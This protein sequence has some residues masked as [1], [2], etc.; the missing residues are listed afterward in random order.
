MGCG[1]GTFAVLLATRGVRV[2]GVDPAAA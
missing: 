1:T 2:I